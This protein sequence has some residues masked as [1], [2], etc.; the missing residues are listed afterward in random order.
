M[1]STNPQHSFAV[2]LTE[3]EAQRGSATSQGRTAGERQLS[4][5]LVGL[6]KNLGLPP[7]GHVASQM[8]GAVAPALGS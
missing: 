2:T 5:R 3:K 6:P 8:K 7:P 4:W 1:F